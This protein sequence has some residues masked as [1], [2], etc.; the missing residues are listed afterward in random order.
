MVA[1]LTGQEVRAP[2]IA[3]VVLELRL[4]RAV[5]A[6]GIGAGLAAAG[7]GMQAVFRNPLAD[8][9]LIGVSSGAAVGAALV[10]VFLRGWLQDAPP[11][12][13]AIALPLAAFV[14]GLV[15]TALVFGLSRTDEHHASSASM[16]LMGIAINALGFAII[17]LANHLASGAQLRELTL[18]LF[19]SLAG[20]RWTTAGPALLAAAVTSGWLWRVGR[21]LDAL[22]LGTAPAS[23]LGVD[24]RRLE[25]DVVLLGALAV[26]TATAAA[27]VIGFVGLVV[28]HV[29]RL[30]IGPLHRHVVPTSALLG[31]VVM[32]VA[33]TLARTL[34]VPEELPVGV[35]LAAVGAPF[36]LGLLRRARAGAGLI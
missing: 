18:W 3:S 8:P 25:R 35:L 21:S 12:L 2:W 5:L 30:L 15:A 33:D 6:V 11:A 13:E 24:V 26:G 1:T 22:L 29:A 10:L 17:G 19:G 36:F 14:G 31:A 27:G 23:D 34:S 9:A 16:L 28:P 32:L 4:P 7:A 20:A